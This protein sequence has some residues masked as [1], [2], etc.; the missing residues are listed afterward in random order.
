MQLPRARAL[1][2]LG[3]RTEALAAAREARDALSRIP[4]RRVANNEAV[5]LLK[6]LERPDHRPRGSRK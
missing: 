4:G 3:R 1:L 5:A 6:R 2:E